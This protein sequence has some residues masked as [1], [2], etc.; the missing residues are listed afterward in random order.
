[1]N[2]L[3]LE[4]AEYRIKEFRSRYPSAIFVD[5]AQDCIDQLQNP[6]DLLFLDHDL[7]G[8]IHV[9]PSDPN[10]GSEVVR[11]I[12]KNNPQI[13]KI[14]V[15]THNSNAAKDMVES[16]AAFNVERIRFMDLVAEPES[17]GE[18]P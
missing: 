12:V 6:V 1:M 18:R 8:K 15:H 10:T 7:E 14:I 9:D 13:G 5:S 3:I 2:I 4:D 16:L 11:W 17:D